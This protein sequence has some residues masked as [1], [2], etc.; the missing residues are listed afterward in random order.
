[1][2]G[3]LRVGLVGAGMVAAYHI[4]GW[5][6]CPGATLVGVADPDPARARD[7]ATAAGAQAFP[8]LAEMAEIGLD[9]VD[10]VAPA[11]IHGALIDEAL[12]HGLHVKCQKPLAP[13]HASARRIVDRLPDGARVMIHEN[14]RWRPQYR[15]LRMAM[16]E[17]TLQ[18]PTGFEFRVESSGLLPRPDGSFPALERQPFFADMPRFLVLELLIHHLDTLEFLFGPVEIHS[19]RLDRRCMAIRGEDLA[20]I[21]LVAGGVPGRLIGDFCVPGAPPLPRDRLALTGSE[22]PV[23]DGWR[24]AL[25]GQPG[26]DFDP[27]KAYQQSYTDTIGHFVDC[28]RQNRVFETPAQQGL[29]ALDHVAKIYAIADPSLIPAAAT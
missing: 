4:A 2:A 21:T 27:E 8:S 20:V 22:V 10:I 24:I 9:A 15:A 26:C 6:D 28:I 16:E 3:D 18:R 17:D 25:P 23:V 11:P 5:S 1:M 29:R 12:S 13:D 14:W 19:A 7:R